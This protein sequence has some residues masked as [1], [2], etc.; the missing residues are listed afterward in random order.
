MR[1]FIRH[2]AGIPICYTLPG[3]IDNRGDRLKNISRG[4]LCFTTGMH[5]DPGK[6]IDIEIS[7][8]DPVFKALG[9]V[10][11]CSKNNGMYYVGVRFRDV[12]TEFAMRLVEQVCH[13][14]GYR[15]AILRTEGRE[16]TSEEA[17][18]EWIAKYSET[19]PR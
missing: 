8:V 19:F 7:V 12:E 16:L 14:E 9:V 5:I 17:A 6:L 11:W 4:G 1:E 2:P 15:Q 18:A 13:M 10:V 3:S